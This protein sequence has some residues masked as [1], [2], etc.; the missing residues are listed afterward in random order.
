MGLILTERLINIPAEL[1]PPMYGMLLEEINWAL[2][3]KEPYELTDYIILSKTYKEVESSADQGNER[4]KKKSKSEKKA[5]TN[6]ETFYF[7]VEDEV[8]QQHA[9]E[10]GSYAYSRKD[11]ES[12][13]D[14]RRAFQELGI[15]P[16]GHLMLITASKFEG[17]V[18]A[19]T[20]F[21]PQP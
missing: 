5:N 15:R 10:S 8:L 19:I 7:H 1:V 21:L 18:Q 16:Q 3:E 17:A 4:P 11:A 14:S 12:T 9:D 20:R 2:E 6:A 13:P